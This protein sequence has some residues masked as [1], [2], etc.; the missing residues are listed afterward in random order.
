MSFSRAGFMNFYPRL[1]TSLWGRALRKTGEHIHTYVGWILSRTIK[2]ATCLGFTVCLAGKP[3]KKMCNCPEVICCPIKQILVTLSVADTVEVLFIYL[4]IVCE[5]HVYV[6]GREQLYDIISL[7]PL[8]GVQEWNSG[9]Q[10]RLCSKCLHRL[11][12]L[13]D[14]WIP[15]IPKDNLESSD[16]LKMRKTTTWLENA[17]VS[18]GSDH[19]KGKCCLEQSL[20]IFHLSVRQAM[21]SPPSPRTETAGSKALC[22]QEKH[23]DQSMPRTTITRIPPT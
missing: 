7:L 6:E 10:A 4:F 19:W 12:P 21:S 17:A 5:E 11:S 23:V 15:S 2:G 8:C 22:P 3:Q 16:V 13:P 18:S 9:C 1:L 14:L 20:I